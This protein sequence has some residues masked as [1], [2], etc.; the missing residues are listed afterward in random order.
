M[1]AIPRLVFLLGILNDPERKSIFKIS[2]EFFYLFFTY[3]KLPKHYFKWDLYK[4]AIADPRDH[5]PSQ[6]L[7]KIPSIFNDQKVKEVLDNKLYFNYFYRQSCINLP[8]ILMYNHK[9]MFVMGH[10]NFHVK[11]ASEFV[12]LLEKM[13][14]ENTGYDSIIIKKIYSGSM[15]QDNYKLFLH[16]LKS[17]PERINEIYSRVI[18]SEFLFQG[19]VKQHPE[20]DKLNPSS[21]NTI[22]FDTFINR[23]GTVEIMSAFI[24]MSI[25]ENH[26][27]NISSGGCMAGVDLR[28]GNLHKF[29]YT[30]VK[31]LGLKV[32]TKHPLT[33]TTFEGFTIPY[34]NQAKELVI[35]AAGLM[36]G[37]RLVGWDV[38]IGDSGP[39]LVEG[40]SDYD[41]SGNDY[42]SGGYNSNP[43]FRKVLE[44]VEGI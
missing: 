13:A 6:T 42:I 29:A 22:R 10:R 25:N 23:D 24:R 18:N 28:T 33:G 35:K 4:K 14:N 16:K 17:D 7:G 30:M 8:K 38:G 44:E 20:L 5:L 19:T 9:N 11:I 3:H 21:L 2:Y 15:G 41:I 40:N 31:P 34:F 37:L 43:I 26:I 27:D 12:N 39:V 1:N 32:H 36:P